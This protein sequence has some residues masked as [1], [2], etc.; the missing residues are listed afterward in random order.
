MPQWTA[1][2]RAETRCLTGLAAIVLALSAVS[3]AVAADAAAPRIAI[4]DEPAGA[5]LRVLDETGSVS[6]PISVHVTSPAFPADASLDA[7]LAALE[8]RHVPVWLTIAAPAT[9]QDVDPWRDAL[10]RLLESRGATLH[11]LEV[12]V[13]RQPARVASFAVQVAATEVRTARDA[14]RVALGGSAMSDRVRREEIDLTELAPYVDLLVANAGSAGGVGGWLH[15]LDSAAMLVLTGSAP[16]NRPS[17]PARQIVDA[18]LTELGTDVTLHEWPAAAVTPAALRAL[19]PISDLLV[20]EISVLDP[21]VAG[22]SLRVGD[23]DVTSSLRHKLLFDSRTFATY[24]V[25]WGD[26]GQPALRMSLVLP[27][28]GVPGVHDLVAGARTSAGGYTRETGTGRVQAEAPLTGR[29]MIVDFNEGAGDVLIERSGA[30]AVR[31]LTIGEIVAR[32]QRQQRAQ[33]AIVRNYIATARMQQHFRPTVADNGMSSS[34]DVV[35]ENRYFVNGSDVEWEELSFAVNGSRFGI[36]RPPFPMLQPEKVLSLPL[37]LRFDEGYTYRLAGSERVDGFDCYVVKFDPV[38]EDSALYKGTVWIDKRSFARVR[39]QAVQ[40]GLAAPVISNEETQHY[41]PVAVGNRPVFL[42]SGLSARQI[43]LIAGRNLLVEKSVEFS[44]FRVN[45][46]EFDRERAS[47]R[48]SDRV[49]YRETDRGLRYYVKEDGKRVISERPTSHAKALAIGTTIDPS[50]SYP[51]PMLGI[52]YLNFQ[53][54][55]PNQQLAVLFAGVLAAGNIQRSRIGHTR[56][57]ASVDFFAIA[58]PASDR[59]YTATGESR[60]ER[61]LTWPETTGFNLGWQATPF[62]KASFQ[63]QL[64]FDG[65]TK[66]TTTA[67]TFEVPSSTVTQ[68]FGGAW[69]YRRAGYSLLLNG[70]WFGRAAWQPWGLPQPGQPA[71]TT[72]SPAA[73]EKYQAS[74]SRDFFIG[75]F[76]KLHLNGAYFG[77]QDL[78]R[79]SRYQ[80]GLFDDTRIHGVPSSGVRYGELAMARGS[81]S[82]NVFEQYRLDLF[83]DRAWGRDDPGHGAWDPITGLGVAVNVR[84]PWNTIL[85]ADVGKS[86]LPARYGALGSTVFQIL[87]LKPMR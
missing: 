21:A 73:Y 51:L 37:Q 29:P 9:E 78:D 3:T 60:G 16:A 38:R 20:D 65:Y 2:R 18:L 52:D 31:Q 77:G 66:D 11:L 56:L 33:D 86:F 26:A 46:A 75:P 55:S 34:F 53:F 27:V 83:L 72:T 80:F 6:F 54:G 1:R 74:L 69:E 23:A 7:R 64:R 22:L 84:A 44:D 39:V 30:S 58:A 32:H 71:A 70:T 28:E 35:T 82:L 25:Y 14:I 12:A 79:F 48:E 57:D 67:D 42:F 41:R 59:L 81:Y 50:Y 63:Y 45:H 19:L 4:G 87:L 13:D 43:V 8:G 15:Q 40:G 17:E 24:L 62:Q 5:A 85:R 76:Q 68:G 49:M 61:V 47:A 36:D 10:R